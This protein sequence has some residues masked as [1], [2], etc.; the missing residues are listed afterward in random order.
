M[1]KVKKTKELILMAHDDCEAGMASNI[2]YT[3]CFHA[4]QAVE[5]YLKAFLSFH[6]KEVP[7]THNLRDLI[8]KCGQ[9]DS[10]LNN[11]LSLT[12]SL[13]IFAVEIR[14]SSSKEIAGKKCPEA[15]QAMI[16]ILDELKRRMPEM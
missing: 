12:D 13:Q 14:Y 11:L 8:S 3:I 10:S 16:K 4:Q 9:I 2:P 6:N 5:K 1:D 15:W 7:K